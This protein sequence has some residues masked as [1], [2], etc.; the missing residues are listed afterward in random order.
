[1][2]RKMRKAGLARSPLS[3]QAPLRDVGQWRI[4]TTAGQRAVGEAGK[5]EY[6][7]SL[8]PRYNVRKQLLKT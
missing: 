5:D 3:T 4:F 2:N 1:M 6:K 8:K 7:R